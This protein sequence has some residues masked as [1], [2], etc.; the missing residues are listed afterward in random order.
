MYGVHII[1]ADAERILPIRAILDIDVLDIASKLARDPIVGGTW[2][3]LLA[4]DLLVLVVVAETVNRPKSL[5]TS[6]LTF[7][8]EKILG[9]VG[10]Y[11]IG[12][13]GC[14]EPISF[15]ERIILF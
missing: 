6:R 3:R 2:Q 13:F 10:V 11:T 7:F 4:I 5:P 8:F 12:H 15:R 9:V 1:S 14:F